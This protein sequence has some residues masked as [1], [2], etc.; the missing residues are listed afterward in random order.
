MRI[1][2]APGSRRGIVALAIAA[3]LALVRHRC[4]SHDRRC[5]VRI[6]GGRR[7]S[8]RDRQVPGPH[9][10]AHGRPGRPWPR[11]CPRGWR[12]G[13]V[14]RGLRSPRSRR[15]CSG[16]PPT[17]S[18]ASSRCRRT[19]HGDG[20]DAGRPGRASGPRRADHD[21]PAGLHGPQCVRGSPR[22]QDHAAH[23]PEPHGRLHPRGADRQQLRARSGDLR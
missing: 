1:V 7:G 4:R 19:V 13:P 6:G 22:R 18:S 10:G 9:P 17:R 23:A 3:C 16:R 2:K 8:R 11:R 12:P 15:F 14:D 21:L 5:R 20:R